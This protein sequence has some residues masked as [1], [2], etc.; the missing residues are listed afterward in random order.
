[1]RSRYREGGKS[2]KLKKILTFTGCLVLACTMVLGAACFKE[3]EQTGGGNGNTQTEQAVHGTHIY[4]IKETDKDIIA[5]GTSDYKI[6]IPSDASSNTELAASELQ[7]FLED[8]TGVR[9]AIA[10]E[11]QD[12][13]GGKYFSLGQTT[14]LQENGLSA[15]YEQLG[16]DGFRI[17][18]KGD[19]IFIFGYGD[20]ASLYGVY[21]YLEQELDYDFF[22][23][24]VWKIDKT[25]T[26]PLREYD[27]TD[28]P[29]FEQRINC[30]G[31]EKDDS[32]VRARFRH[33]TYNEVTIPVNG[34]R[35]HNSLEYIPYDTWKDVTDAEGRKYGDYWYNSSG[36][37][38]CFTAHGDEAMLAA[39]QD[40]VIRQLEIAFEEDTVNNTVPFAVEDLAPPCNCEKCSQVTEQ[41]GALSAVEIL[42]CNEVAE[43]FEKVLREKGDAR[44]D[45]FRL[46]FYAYNQY[47]APPVT[48]TTDAQGKETYSY[49]PEMKLNDHVIPYWMSYYMDCSHSIYSEVNS[50]YLQELKGWNELSSEIQIYGYDTNFKDYLVSLFSHYTLKD[51]I[52]ACYE[53]GATHLYLQGQLDQANSTTAYGL[54]RAYLTAKLGWSVDADVDALTEDFFDAMYGTESETMKTLFEEY[55]V[56]NTW[57]VEEGGYSPYV[58]FTGCKSTAF[59]KR[60]VLVSW[61]D[62][63]FAAVER[64][65]AAGDE[66]SVMHVRSELLMPLYLLVELYSTAIDAQTLQYYK[67]QFALCVSETG[68]SK[69]AENDNYPITDL[70]A[71][72]GL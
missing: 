15:T 33:V 37:Q 9:L 56:Y 72:W 20:R 39:M 23:T 48:V 69:Y 5:N 6:L 3:Q 47:S 12:I 42:F 18:T 30:W 59:W 57:L 27:A 17:V 55:S 40:E 64:L 51:Y 1:M 2:M 53:N 70:L 52:T 7:F 28:I 46:V 41:Y 36:T 63:M 44:A 45:N 34:A 4:N 35:Y 19:N 60:P 32:T 29:D 21:G 67:E 26:L 16:S 65:E 14:L 10:E 66:A 62:R 24:D 68:I 43:K 8:A 50:T 13:S 38:P 54:L 58:N 49:A 11:T 61:A 25:D 31:F 22:F 71:S